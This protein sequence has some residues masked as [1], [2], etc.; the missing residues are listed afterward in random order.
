M[1][2]SVRPF[3]VA[4][5]AAAL[6]ATAALAQTAPARPAPARPA[7]ALPAADTVRGAPEQADA[8]GGA[9]DA[10]RAEQALV[11]RLDSVDAAARTGL[12][13]MPVPVAVSLIESIRPGL[14][15]SDRAVLRSIAGDLDALRDEL[16][17]RSVNGR[18]VGAILRRVGPKVMTVARTQSGAV[19]AALQHIGEQLTAAGGRLA[20]GDPA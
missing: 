16:G 17:A 6:P 18:R 15:A 11:A 13:G 14:H 5:F 9:Q 8:P 19:R 7:P 10:A 3:A 20:P 4:A 1:R 12:T 2:P